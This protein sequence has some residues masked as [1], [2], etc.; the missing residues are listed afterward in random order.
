MLAPD[1]S[2]DEI[3]NNIASI[4]Q[5]RRE[6]PLSEVTRSG[7]SMIKLAEIGAVDKKVLQEFMLSIVEC[8]EDKRQAARQ[9]IEQ[10]YGSETAKLILPRLLNEIN[11]RLKKLMKD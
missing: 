2:I 7:V 8:A 5:S 9:V 1:P 3:K 10:V 6:F 4:S 11:D